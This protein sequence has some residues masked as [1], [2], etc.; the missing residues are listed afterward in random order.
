MRLYALMLC[1]CLSTIAFGQHQI[2]GYVLDD[3]GRAIEFGQVVVGHQRTI[4]QS[5]G[6]FQVQPLSTGTYQLSVI[7]EG[8]LPLQMQVELPTSDTLWL[9]LTSTLHEE[10]DE[11]IVH[12]YEEKAYNSVVINH[13]KIQDQYSGSLA[14]SLATLP[15]VQAMEIGSST[16]KPLIRGLGFTRIA[17]VENGI[18]QEG[19]QWGADHGL[20]IDALQA[21]E[22]EIIKGVGAIAYGSDAIGGV[23][24]INNEKI[25]FQE[26]LSGRLIW[27][28]KTVN[29]AMGMSALL[30]NRKKNWFYKVKFSG[31]D[32][33]DFKVPTSEINYLN[34]RIPIYNHQMKNTAGQEYSGY[35]Q[36]G[37][38]H[39]KLES[40]LSVSYLSSKIGFFPGAHGIPN[41]S[42]SDNDDAKRSV[43][44]PYQAVDHFKINSSTRWLQDDSTW[45][46]IFG[47]QQNHRQEISKFHTHYSNQLAPLLHPNLELD[48]LLNTIDSQLSYESTWREHV[49]TFGVQHNLQLNDVAGYSYLLPAYQRTGLGLYVQHHWD[50]SSQW[51]VE[52]GGRFDVHQLQIDGFFDPILYDYLLN[53]GKS[54]VTAQSYA[55][56]STSLKKNFKQAQFSL[57]SRFNVSKQWTFTLTAA[58]SFRLPTA[59]E[60]SANGIHHGAFRHEKGNAHLNPEKGVAVELG[61]SYQTEGFS[62][63][64]TPYLYYFSNYI[65]LQPSG[66]FSV[67]PHGGQV[68]EYQQSKALLSGFELTFEKQWGPIQLEGVWE[69]LYNQQITSNGAN[70]ALP[71]TPPMNVY[72]AL[73]YTLS[74][75]SWLK[76]TQV[77]VTTKWA[78]G[79][80]RI[81]QNEQYTP[82]YTSFGASIQSELQWGKYQPILRLQATNLLNTTY[83]QH[84]SFYRAIEIPELSRSIQL[85]ITLPF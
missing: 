68:Y 12:A 11:L 40:V 28:G 61:T 15:G 25:P 84:A 70:Y 23:V 37:Y 7:A 60:L 81:A 21:E 9:Q 67:L 14:S 59:M 18:K 38:V 78:D 39:D 27:H 50:V 72:A 22:V 5:N 32:F 66:Q 83:Y 46:F 19:Q 64:F 76:K 4:S 56:R 52:I 53:T 2:T 42:I 6:F 71:F 49:T 51:L 31:L 77:S 62:A 3:H 65:F 63:S 29:E 48:F 20:E 69:Y 47:Y 79:Q 85:M 35:L 13:H 58:N 75:F 26:G 54:V 17:V 55:Q 57:G 45:K 24:R 44:F 10:L 36:A 82:G 8:F 73:S 33:A 16:S 74:D 41:S 30:Q 1:F 43:N 80:R 34:T